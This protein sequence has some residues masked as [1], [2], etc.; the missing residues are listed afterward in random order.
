MTLGWEASSLS[1]AAGLR[2]ARGD[3]I[4]VLDGVFSNW[5]GLF[6]GMTD[7]ERVTVNVR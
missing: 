7:E 4:R 3:Q 6:E 1:I 5:I 2:F